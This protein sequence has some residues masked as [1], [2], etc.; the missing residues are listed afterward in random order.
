M[1]LETN[2][3]IE[4]VLDSKN[5][6][7]HSASSCDCEFDITKAGVVP[8]HAYGIKLKNILIPNTVY[9]VNS[10]NNVF[11]FYRDGILSI[12]MTP[13]NYS[14]TELATYLTTEMNAVS[15]LFT[16]SYDAKTMKFTF[17]RSAAT[18]ELLFAHDNNPWE[19]LGFE[20][21]TDYAAAASRTSVNVADLS[22]PRMVFVDIVNTNVNSCISTY[23][24]N[25]FN[26]TF[27]VPLSSGRGELVNVPN[28][29]YHAVEINNSMSLHGNINVKLKTETGAILDLNGANWTIHFI[30]Y[31][32]DY[33][34]SSQSRKRL[35]LTNSY[36]H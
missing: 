5:R 12:T 22:R 8:D 25:R 34:K 15:S 21:G 23:S 9:N 31:H 11:K 27:A 1:D 26:T 18:F 30:L 4:L 17:S 2:A 24:D 29:E 28:R 10:S 20:D 13:G 32:C 36:S 14:A 7:S 19:L 3:A 33:D 6:L 16:V 35:R